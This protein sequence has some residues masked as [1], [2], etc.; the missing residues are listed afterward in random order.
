[1]QDV[2]FLSWDE[3]EPILNGFNCPCCMGVRL[4][5]TEEEL[6]QRITDALEDRQKELANARAVIR[7]LDA[8]RLDEIFSKAVDVV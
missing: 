3:W 8:E 2:E 1:M 5:P 7:R 6:E 4:M